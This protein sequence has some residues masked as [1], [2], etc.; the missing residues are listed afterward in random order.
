M[1]AEYYE[2]KQV[3]ILQGELNPDSLMFKNMSKIETYSKFDMRLLVDRNN[4]TLIKSETWMDTLKVVDIQSEYTDVQKGIFLPIE[5]IIK[6]EYSGGLPIS[7]DTPL[8]QDT[9]LAV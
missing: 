1:G 8:V 6:F 7:V 5:T 3:W 2:G 9:N 4:W